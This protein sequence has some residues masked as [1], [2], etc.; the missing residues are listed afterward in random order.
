MGADAAEEE[1]RSV[2]VNVRAGI[3]RKALPGLHFAAFHAVRSLLAAKG[4]EPTTQK[5][6]HAMFALNLVKPGT[7]STSSGR[8]LSE[9]QAIRERADHQVELSYDAADWRAGSPRRGGFSTSSRHCSSRCGTFAPTGLR[10]PGEMSGR[11]SV[12]RHASGHRPEVPAHGAAVIEAAAQA[13]AEVPAS[14]PRGH[15]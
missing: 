5:G 11:R 4:L 13:R 3:H 9:L 10:R 14:T 2:L 8:I 12:R 1:L 6:G 15:G 7:V